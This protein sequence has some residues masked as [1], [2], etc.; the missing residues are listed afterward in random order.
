MGH[1]LALQSPGLLFSA[2]CSYWLIFFV[3]MLQHDFRNQH[4]DD[5]PVTSKNQ[6]LG[7]SVDPS[8][9]MSLS[10]LHW[11]RPIWCHVAATAVDIAQCEG[12]SAKPSN[13]Q[14]GSTSK[15][16]KS[17]AWASSLR[18]CLRP[19]GSQNGKGLTSSKTIVSTHQLFHHYWIKINPHFHHH[20]CQLIPQ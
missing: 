14:T 7:E 17:L 11:L 12:W 20:H 10:H 18:S 9:Q 1:S 5:H 8:S 6:V 3:L 13:Q 15:W 2:K 19:I 4:R 16:K